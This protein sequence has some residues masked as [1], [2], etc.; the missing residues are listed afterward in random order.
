MAS[1]GFEYVFPA[2]RG[3]QAQR[4][5]YVS[6]CLLSLIPKI[7]LFDEEELVAE[8]RA[9]RSLN[10][11]RIPAMT[12]YI[13]E[14]TEDYVFSALTASVDG[15]V[16]FEPMLEAD[17][18]GRVGLLHIPMTAK[19]IIND[20]QHRRA[21]I[22]AALRE[23]PELAHE[24]IS[25]VLFR[26]IG[27]ERCQQM[28]ADL[29]RYAIRPSK[30]LGLLYDHRD[31]LAQVSKLV[32]MKC[33]A[34]RGVV[35]TEKSTLSLRSRKLFTLSALHSGTTALLGDRLAPEDVD[36][37][38]QLGVEF[39]NAVDRQIPEWGAVRRREIT[40]GEVRRDFIH[41]HGVILQALGRAGY[42]L[43]QARP[44]SW[45]QQIDRLATIDWTRANAKTWEGRAMIGGQVSKA[46]RNVT[47]ATNVLKQ[48]LDLELTPDE[49]R[50]ETAFLR[51]ENEKAD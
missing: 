45:E 28:F 6:M 15:D 10:R 20:G 8:L 35:E 16:R 30:S 14:N 5:Y 7:F 42:A 48:T 34:F 12:R 2:I 44:R 46:R 36:D 13:V 11:G 49:H 33:E 50:V 19:F 21:A 43:L 25:V 38:A 29:N 32:M 41:T 17:A 26:D 18:D 27:L 31:V 4:E 24:S 40:A 51:G 9:Q 23:R 1:G 39:W 22:Q 47:L 37:A 3:V